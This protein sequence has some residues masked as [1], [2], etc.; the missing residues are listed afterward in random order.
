MSRR[1]LRPAAPHVNECPRCG[2]DMEHTSDMTKTSKGAWIHKR[3][4]GGADDE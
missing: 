3:C 2:E 1:N 4:A